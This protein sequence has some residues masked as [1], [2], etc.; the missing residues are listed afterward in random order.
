MRRTALSTVKR[1]PKRAKYEFEDIAGIM[2]SSFIC[3]IGFVFNGEPVVIPTIYG[4][5]R[6]QLFFHGA[7]TSRMLRVMKEGYRIS[8][9]VTILDGIVLA[10]SAF[11]H[12]IN[13][14]SV[15]LFGN[16]NEVIGENNKL[17]A[18]KVISDQ[19]APGRWEEVRQPNKKELKATSV[20]RMQIDEGSAKVRTG[21]P[22]DDREDYELDV[23]AGIVPLKIKAEDPVQDEL[24]KDNILRPGSIS[25]LLKRF[26]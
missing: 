26:V 18:L 9:A 21:P 17:E 16:A 14:R 8:L 19:V 11:H 6:D 25:A 20:Y 7:T 10:R 5:K 4:R 23:W 3:H 12:S 15:V 1:L 2:D 24:L 22:I 13:Y